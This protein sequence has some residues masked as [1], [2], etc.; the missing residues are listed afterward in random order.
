LKTGE[1]CISIL[2]PPGVD[3]MSGENPAERWN[4]TQQVR[5]ILLSVISLLNEPNISSPANV[6]ASVSYR[7][8]REGLDD[9][10]ATRVG[11]QVSRS[12]ELA[13]REGVV[14]PVTL[15]E[16]L[17][18]PSRPPPRQERCVPLAPPLLNLCAMLTHLWIAASTGCTM[19]IQDLMTATTR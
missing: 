15:E 9:D 19:K 7:R 2:H 6:D 10:Y 13:R 16:Y 18:R 3:E 12:K 1:L 5:T 4:P 17:G 14:V 11:T 8:W